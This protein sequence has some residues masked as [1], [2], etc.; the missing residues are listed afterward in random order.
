MT[1]ATHQGHAIHYHEACI[2][3]RPFTRTAEGQYA[4]HKDRRQ[5]NKLIFKATEKTFQ[6]KQRMA[7]KLKLPNETNRRAS[8]P[9]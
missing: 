2:S 5:Y 7:L 3:K 1:S 6:Q 8:G 4:L 9:L